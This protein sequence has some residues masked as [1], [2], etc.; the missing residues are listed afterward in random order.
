[1]LPLIWGL[2]TTLAIQPTNR[3]FSERL[4][5]IHMLFSLLN[6]S[7]L[8]RRGSMVITRWDCNKGLIVSEAND[9]F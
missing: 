9:S 8:H 2:E 5:R 7:D 1:M 3:M 6:L 4:N